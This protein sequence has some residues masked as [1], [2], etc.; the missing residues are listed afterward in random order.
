MRTVVSEI[1]LLKRC[2]K[3]N[4]RAFEVIVAKYQELICAITFSGTTNIQQSEE[5][6]HQT[7]INA[8]K[9]LSQL[10]NPAKFRAWLCTIARNNIR[11][12]LN[13]NKRDI[14]A[15][16][17]PME[18]IND[19]T[20][21]EAGP[22][23]SAIKK[24]HEELVSDAIRRIPEQYREPL[25]LYYRQQQSVK[26]VALSLD[27]SQDVV[28][29]RLHRGRKMIKEKL[30]SIVEQTLSATGPKKAFTTAVIA[31]IAGMAIKSSGV[32][33]TASI[34][35]GTSTTGTT[36]G[37]AAIMSG[38]TGKIITAVA[39]AAIGVGAVV[40]YRQVT[41]S[42]QGPDL[43]QAGM[44]VQKQ[45]KDQVIYNKQSNE[46]DSS[47]VAT[48][49]EFRHPLEGEKEKTNVIKDTTTLTQITQ[50]QEP[51]VQPEKTITYKG[52]VVNESGEP[53]QDIN[54][55]SDFSYYKTREYIVG[56][57]QGTTDE[58]GNFEIGP[59]T[60]V[61]RKKGGRTIIFDHPDYAVG[62]F[63]P[64]RDKNINPNSVKV[65]LLKPVSLTGTVSDE[66]GKPIEGATIEASL[67]LMMPK[68]YG[69]F[70]MTKSNKMA[71]LTDDQGYF[72]LGKIPE[73]S[74]LHINIEK[75]GYATYH[76]REGYRNDFYPI[77]TEDELEIVLEPGGVIRGQLILNGR[78]YEKEG[79]TVIA[80]GDGQRRFKL[81]RTDKQ[82]VFEIIELA[83]DNYT[84]TLDT[85]SAAQIGLVCQPVCNYSVKVDQAGP[86]VEL[87]LEKGFPITV[88]VIDKDTNEPLKKVSIRTTLQNYTNV[89]IVS[90]NTNIAGEHVFQLT[91]GK[92]TLFANGWKNGRFHQFSKNFSVDPNG[93]ESTIV[94]AITSRPIIYGW[95]IDVN[96][97]PI[98]GKVTL[99]SDYIES[100]EHGE[101]AIPEPWDIPGGIHIGYAF[102]MDKNLGR[103]YFW[104]KSEDFNDLE[105]VLAPFTKITGRVV[106]ENGQGIENLK[107]RIGI[108]MPNGMF[109]YSQQ[110]LWKT[111][112]E[113]EGH[114]YFE[115]VPVGLPMELSAEKPGYFNSIQLP[116]LKPGETMDVDQLVLQPRYGFEKGQTDW[117]ESLTGRVINE[118]NE[119]MIGLRVWP[120]GPIGVSQDVTNLEGRYKLDKL[121]R[122]K[123]IK[124]G[125]YADGY[126]HIS[127]KKVLDGNDFD[128][129]IFL[130]GWDLLGKQAPQLVVRKWLNK[131]TVSLENHLGKVVLLQI[132]VLLPNYSDQFNRIVRV[133]EKYSDKGLEVIAIHEPLR[134]TWAGKVTEDDILAFIQKNDIKFAFGIDDLPDKVYDIVEKEK[135]KNGA[136][137]SL[138]HI[139]VTPA[140]YL[141][142][143]KGILGISPTRDNLDQWIEKL[144][145]E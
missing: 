77:K 107:Q 44:I 97:Q 30:S 2:L 110:N 138:Y 6:A 134:V 20:A 113:P 136:T 123:T 52:I 115:D 131:D 91:P 145:A 65:T 139:K 88:K 3:G 61:D 85:E 49:S 16:A 11:D 118:N 7:F 51:L 105:I 5:L 114:F 68:H 57:T 38:V 108:I 121:P 13:K 102:D 95:L 33:A 78:N 122:G 19:T 94:M 8:W 70:S 69:Y 14:I 9:N 60:L 100:D 143:K 59:L 62:W 24:E 56:E 25:V 98:Q 141:I 15:G 18:N 50:T 32:A 64:N 101:F 42:E 109:R 34:V 67:Q 130:Q 92:Y 58:K 103:G 45:E 120:D 79:L 26:Q 135:L 129:Q 21:D 40:T 89:S 99:R 35:A 4:S 73:G 83:E 46:M 17:K 112:L 84:V 28:R 133:V 126:G 72:F 23:E 48:S 128:M 144:L 140:L 127:F 75:K 29:Q 137:G 10:E 12:F 47:L 22:L 96:D 93:P 142:D 124:V 132:G 43:P 119:P 41:K 55:R 111:V 90:G 71:A 27:L 80:Q 87:K 74:R 37:V 81:T 125:V 63:N 53:I 1:E 76:T 116:K 31:S 104:E 86:N 106:D 117:T 54:I 39:V 36:T 66:A 82:G